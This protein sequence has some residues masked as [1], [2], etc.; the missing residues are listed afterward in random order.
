MSISVDKIYVDMDGVI[1]DFHKRYTERYRMSPAEADGAGQFGKF[2]V[3]FIADREFSTLELMEDAVEL[4]NFL[5]GMKAPKEILSSTA[6]VE[7]HSSISAQKNEWLKHHNIN[8]VQNFVPGK[9]LKY[10]FA[11][12]NSII[13]DDTKSVIDDWNNAGGIGL[14]HTDAKSTIAM[15]KKYI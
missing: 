3:K 7:N 5:N 8:Y 12:P 1:A 14:H 13:I 2:F 4:L 15:L 11:T 10:R 9:H 6:R